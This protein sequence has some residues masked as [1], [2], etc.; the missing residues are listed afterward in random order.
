MTK[1]NDVSM[2]YILLFF[3]WGR[4]GESR[5]RRVRM[6]YL[7]A[8]ESSQV[9]LLSVQKYPLVSAFRYSLKKK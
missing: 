9:H 8:K 7:I 2:K 4:E 3:I 6:V 5:N 1:E